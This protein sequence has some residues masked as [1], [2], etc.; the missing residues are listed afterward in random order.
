MSVRDIL[1]IGALPIQLEL[2]KDFLKFHHKFKITIERKSEY[3][4]D[5][6]IRRKYLRFYQKPIPEWIT[7]WKYLNCIMIVKF[8]LTYRCLNCILISSSWKCLISQIHCNSALGFILN[9]SS[10]YHHFQ[11]VQDITI[12]LKRIA[13]L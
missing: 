10:I 1:L 11:T 9:K 4:K 7:H 6:T 3:I 5:S 12:K 8:I 2:T 13:I